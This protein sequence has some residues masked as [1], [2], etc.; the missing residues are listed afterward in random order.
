MSAS[1]RYR[2]RRLVARANRWALRQDA[3]PRARDRLQHIG[4][5]ASLWATVKLAVVAAI[6]PFWAPAIMLRAAINNVRARRLTAAFPEQIRAIAEGRTPEPPANHVVDV[7]ADQR[8]VFFSDLHRSVVGRLDWPRRQHTKQLYEDVLDCYA[9]DDWALCENGDVEDYWIVGGSAYGATYDIMRIAGAALA[10][11]GRTALLTEAYKAHLDQI[12]ANNEGIYDRIRD[13]F[14]RRGRYYRTVGNHDNANSRPMV[15][16][17]LREVLGPFPIADYF[18]LRAPDGR[19][20]GVACHGHHTDGWNAPQ[21]DNLGKLSAWIANTLIDVPLIDTPEGLPDPDAS[22]LML[23]GRLPDRLIQVSRAFGANS[24]YDSMDE[25]LLC[26]AFHAAGLDDVW[27]LLGHTHFP[28][29]G[30]TSR[31]GTHWTRYYNSG[32]GVTDH[33]I[34]AIEW[35]GRAVDAGGDPKVRLVAWTTA[36][37]ETDPDAVE[38]APSGRRVARYVLTGNGTHLATQPAALDIELTGAAG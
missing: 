38:V 27:L 22:E 29:A 31:N 12:V 18:A 2:A 21:R 32:S 6:T 23:E 1:T 17:R 5:F 24:S 13:R 36:N 37:A 9:R 4:W 34:T 30:P 14:V 35:D 15:A 11:L 20:L 10:R 33:V 19:L 3:G 28:V 16:D 25:E 8:I 7:D 26:A